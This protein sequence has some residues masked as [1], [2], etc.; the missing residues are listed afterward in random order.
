VGL[1]RSDTLVTRLE[2]IL[3]SVHAHDFTVLDLEPHPK[4]GGVFV[5]FQ[6]TAPGDDAETARVAALKRIEEALDKQCAKQGGVPSWTGFGQGKMWL[7]RGKPWKEVRHELASFSCCTY[8]FFF[9]QD[10]NRYPS[11]IVKVAFEGPDVNEESLYE[12]LRV[13]HHHRNAYVN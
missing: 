10:L 5:R 4:D 8:N 11:P 9:L 7:V 3:T 1:L 13:C 12:L 2:H 6:Y